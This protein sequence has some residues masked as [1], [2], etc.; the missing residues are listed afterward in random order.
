MTTSLMGCGNTISTTK[1]L[2]IMKSNKKESFY[3]FFFNVNGFL[4]KKRLIVKHH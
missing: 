1:I 2:H 3:L 4:D